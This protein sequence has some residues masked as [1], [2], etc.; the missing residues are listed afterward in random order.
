MFIYYYFKF[1]PIL[2]CE[3]MQTCSNTAKRLGKLSRGRRGCV[4]WLL[5]H[6]TKPPWPH[7]ELLLKAE[8]PSLTDLII[9]FPIRNV[10]CSPVF[11]VLGLFPFGASILECYLQYSQYVKEWG[12]AETNNPA[13]LWGQWNLR[14][15]T[16]ELRTRTR[17]V[18]VGRDH[19]LAK[20]LP[21]T[22]EILD[23]AVGVSVLTL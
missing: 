10:S 4:T 22:Q 8:T 1:Q 6:Y 7:Q 17:V 19:F 9:L 21:F 23:G 20:L 3:D 14:E 18:L 12:H 16:G 5:T 11:S 15:T 13:E 2:E